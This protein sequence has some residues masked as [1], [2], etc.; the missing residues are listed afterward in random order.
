M[1]VDRVQQ[2]VTQLEATEKI[3]K[4]GGATSCILTLIFLIFALL[5]VQVIKHAPRKR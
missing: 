2:G 3:Q 5:V 1:A 4:Q